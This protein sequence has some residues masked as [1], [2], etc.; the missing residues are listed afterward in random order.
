[1]IIYRLA[2]GSAWKCST[3]D[4]TCTTVQFGGQKTQSET[5]F[6]DSADTLA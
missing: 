4:G 1:M 2:D 3:F 6:G 5:T